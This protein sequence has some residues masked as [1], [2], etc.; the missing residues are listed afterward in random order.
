[1]WLVRVKSRRRW[2]QLH[3]LHQTLPASGN[4]LHFP[5]A[6]ARQ[7]IDVVS[8]TEMRKQ[9]GTLHGVADRAAQLEHAVVGD[10]FAQA[11]HGA[12]VG[13]MQAVDMFRQRAFAAAAFADN[14]GD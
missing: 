8:G 11:R 13:S 12:L 3:Q 9:T 2:L 10:C 4:A 7:Q 6:E 5:A 14:R 1:M